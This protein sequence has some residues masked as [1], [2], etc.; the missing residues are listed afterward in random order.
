M[1]K[2]INIL[3]IGFALLCV[4]TIILSQYNCVR[5]IPT[6]LEGIPINDDGTY[7]SFEGMTF[8][9]PEPTYDN[10]IEIVALFSSICMIVFLFCNTI[11]GV[12]GNLFALLQAMVVCFLPQIKNFIEELNH[13]VSCGIGEVRGYYE[14]RMMSFILGFLCAAIFVYSL[15]LTVVYAKE[16]RKR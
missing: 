4:A 12:V 11:L 6:H 16:K 5:F 13:S 10:A 9:L 7:V 1:K 8:E 2:G 3:W 14:P 15:I